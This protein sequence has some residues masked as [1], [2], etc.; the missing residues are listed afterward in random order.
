MDEEPLACDQLFETA[1]GLG[2]HGG[3]RGER[4]LPP[5]I[6][7]SGR[8]AAPAVSACVNSPVNLHNVRSKTAFLQH[9]S[10]VTTAQW[11]PWR[12]RDSV[13]AG[14]RYVAAVALL[15]LERGYIVV[16]LV[17]GL[18]ECGELALRSGEARE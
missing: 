11:L 17:E 3:P 1:G 2:F 16:A 18:F 12:N 5:D 9:H 4:S 15:P 14:G 10:T 13:G 8:D 6:I 7:A